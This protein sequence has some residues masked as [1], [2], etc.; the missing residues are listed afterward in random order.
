M[1]PK[2]NITKKLKKVFVDVLIVIFVRPRTKVKILL[3]KE[4]SFF[5]KTF[6]DKLA[7]FSKICNL[8]LTFDQSALFFSF[9]W[10]LLLVASRG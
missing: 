5:E 8:V 7:M 2:F 6:S 9:L 10:P 1:C 3:S 4:I